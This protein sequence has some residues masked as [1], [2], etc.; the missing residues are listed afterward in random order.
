M[1]HRICIIHRSPSS[2]VIA[3][4][5][6][7]IFFLARYSPYRDIFHRGDPLTRPPAN[8]FLPIHSAR[9]YIGGGFKG[10][11]IFQ[12]STWLK[13]RQSFGENKE[14]VIASLEGISRAIQSE[15]KRGVIEEYCIR[16]IL[17]RYRE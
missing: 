12:E 3:T 17:D 10:E 9:I 15:K 2:F 14:G 13:F 8:S 6:R 5:A 4:R 7:Q 11:R 1:L 16:V